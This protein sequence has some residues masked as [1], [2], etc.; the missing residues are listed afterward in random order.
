ME[1]EN[2]NGRHVIFGHTDTQ[3]NKNTLPGCYTAFLY[4]PGRVAA[5]P[6]GEGIHTRPFLQSQATG[7]NKCELLK[8]DGT[9]RMNPYI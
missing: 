5:V 6:E 1:K 4:L 3:R 2:K 8:C 9:K 7:F